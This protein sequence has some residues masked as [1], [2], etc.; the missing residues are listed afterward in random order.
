MIANL[1]ARTTMS[2]RRGSGRRATCTL[3]L[4]GCAHAHA[5]AGQLPQER[6]LSGFGSESSYGELAMRLLS[7]ADADRFA[8]EFEAAGGTL[9]SQP[10]NPANEKFLVYLPARK[11]ERGYALLVFIPPWPEARLPARWGPVLDQR[12]VIFVTAARSGNDESAIGRREPLALLAT[13]NLMQEY[14]VDPQRV[15]VG[16]FSG[17]SRVALRL[18]LGYPDVFRGAFLNAGSDV[19]GD[20][21][22]VPPVPLPSRE[23]LYRFQESSRLVYATGE[24][25]SDHLADDRSSARSMDQWCVFDVQQFEIARL[26]HSIADAPALA[27]ALD[28]LLAPAQA[29]QDRLARCRRELDAAIDVQLRKLDTLVASGQRDAAERLRTR[30]DRKYGGLAAPRRLQLAP[31]R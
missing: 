25:D 14:P 15:F 10:V 26:D 4:A 16:G 21:A 11:P 17:G 19:I 8:R 27:R 3:L 23:L 9:T 28:A 30:I 13:H 1:S 2:A 6:V 24:L 7:P 29:D 20:A 31:P 12:G 18:A 22:A 5:A